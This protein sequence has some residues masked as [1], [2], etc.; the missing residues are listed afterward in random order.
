MHRAKLWASSEAFE[1]AKNEGKFTADTFIQYHRAV[2][3]LTAIPRL[4]KPPFRHQ[5]A[6]KDCHCAS[7]KQPAK[8]DQRS[9]F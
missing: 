6:H 2:K 1:L 8:A 5:T 7:E 4:A 9:L 3:P